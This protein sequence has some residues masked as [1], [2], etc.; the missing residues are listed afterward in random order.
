MSA[1]VY[2]AGLVLIA[3]SAIAF[4][5]S[6]TASSA[7]TSNLVDLAP[8]SC[9]IHCP[10]ESAFPSLSASV[11][12]TDGSTPACQCADPSRNMAYCVVGARR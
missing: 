3:S 5:L 2:G 6:R 9:A 11:G 10:A 4:A 7:D 8:N 12:C 1:K